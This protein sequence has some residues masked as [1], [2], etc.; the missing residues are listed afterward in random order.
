M[1][2]SEQPVALPLEYISEVSFEMH[3]MR[4]ECSDAAR[5]LLLQPRIDEAA[6]E[7]CAVMDEALAQAKRILDSAVARVRTSR[8]QRKKRLR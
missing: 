3:L 7:D 2:S 4:G 6:L 5:R 8:E 1:N